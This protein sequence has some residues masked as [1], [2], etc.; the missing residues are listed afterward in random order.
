VIYL[1][2]AS[3]TTRRYVYFRNHTSNLNFD[4]TLDRDMLYEVLL[5]LGSS[6]E[7]QLLVRHT[8]V[9]S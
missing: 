2:S 6:G 3:W 7:Q 1:I 8:K 4:L 5:M 9:N